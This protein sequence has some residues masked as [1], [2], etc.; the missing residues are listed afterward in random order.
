MS[1][2][3]LYLIV[4]VIG[5]VLAALTWRTDRGNGRQ[6]AQPDFSTTIDACA[7]PA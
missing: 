7:A 1:I 4:I 5:P 2:V 6:F 3:E